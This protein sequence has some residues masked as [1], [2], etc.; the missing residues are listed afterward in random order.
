[1]TET[2]K[3]VVMI[4]DGGRTMGIPPQFFTAAGY[5]V[6]IFRR[7]EEGIR[8]CRLLK[9]GLIVMDML[10][11]DMPGDETIRALSA[12]P[13]TSDIPVI[14]TLPPGSYPGDLSVLEKIGKRVTVLRRPIKPEALRAAMGAF[15]AGE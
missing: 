4:E 10:M 13:D 12:H 2:E 8:N 5:K 1:M 7:A 9:P 3:T 14:L 11:P 6:E 15:A